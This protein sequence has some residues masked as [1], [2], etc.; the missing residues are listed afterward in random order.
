MF[1]SRRAWVGGHGS[2]RARCGLV[3]IWLGRFAPVLFALQLWVWVWVCIFVWASLRL[4]VWDGWMDN[5]ENPQ[6]RY[7][8]FMAGVGIYSFDLENMIAMVPVILSIETSV[9]M[10]T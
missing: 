7:I 10:S 2:A 3:G 1:R 8:T 6:R 9:R 5:C 4:S